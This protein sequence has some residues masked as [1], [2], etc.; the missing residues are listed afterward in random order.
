MPNGRAS[1]LVVH[2]NA[3]TDCVLT[4]RMWWI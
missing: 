3:V 2:V 4:I 1:T